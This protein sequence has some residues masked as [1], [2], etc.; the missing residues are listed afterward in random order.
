MNKDEI[1][2]RRIQEYVEKNINYYDSY[3]QDYLH[4][5]ELKD[6]RKYR[7]NMPDIYRQILEE[8]GYYDDCIE[9]SGYNAFIN[10]LDNEFGLERNIT[11]VAG[12]V[13]PTLGHKISLKQNKGI[14]TIYDPRLSNYY[15]ESDSFILKREEFFR[16]TDVK[17]SDLLIG[18]MPC[19]ATQAILE[20]A[21]DNNIDFMIAMCE[22]GPHGD[23]FD[24]FENEEEW[25]GA[26]LYLARRGLEDKDMGEL[27]VVSFEDYNS[28]YPL[29]YNKRKQ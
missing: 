12:G 26:M 6:I 3:E 4:N 21:I 25:L 14:I 23:E 13:I 29:I 24:W 16:D 18:F 22:G 27:Q 17:E 20:N 2:N 1:I 15:E 19:E 28:P 11:E 7:N 5:L 10:I 9:K 8:I